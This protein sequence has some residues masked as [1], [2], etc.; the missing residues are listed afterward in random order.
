M[1]KKYMIGVGDEQYSEI[2]IKKEEDL[3]YEHNYAEDEKIEFAAYDRNGDPF[4]FYSYL[5]T[6]NLSYDDAAESLS[7][8]H[9]ELVG[10][11]LQI[12]FYSTD[13]VDKFEEQ[14]DD[15]GVLI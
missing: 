15:W 12:G 3:Y 14:L 5:Q 10:K 2:T 7:S 8:C 13:D 4:T 11:N 9:A 6:T 1:Y